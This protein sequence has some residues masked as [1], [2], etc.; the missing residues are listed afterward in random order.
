[1]KSFLFIFIILSMMF[2][3]E[4]SLSEEM[5]TIY[6]TENSELPGNY[7]NSMV[8]DIDGS[9]WFGTSSGGV[10]QYNSKALIS[11]TE[12][13]GL[14]SRIVWNIH[15]DSNRDLWLTTSWSR[16]GIYKY[17]GNRFVN[18]DEQD[19]LRGLMCQQ[20]EVLAIFICSI[21]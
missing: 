15:Q 4:F 13:D 19:G 18:F 17:D 14:A 7:V 8:I 12:R 11:F 3:S 2:I 16:K 9:I 21:G 5:W 10:C 1:M 6:T 20:G